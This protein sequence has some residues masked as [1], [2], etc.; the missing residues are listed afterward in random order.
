ML[1]CFNC[2]ES[3]QVNVVIISANM[4]GRKKRVITA[5]VFGDVV[6]T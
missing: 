3:V 2:D 5:E 4:N 6:N 1:Y